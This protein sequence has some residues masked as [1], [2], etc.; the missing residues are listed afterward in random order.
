M[1]PR[2]CAGDA[3]GAALVMAVKEDDR[4]SPQ[5]KECLLLLAHGLSNG[6]LTRAEA[7]RRMERYLAA[8]ETETALADLLAWLAAKGIDASLLSARFGWSG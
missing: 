7:L 1:R 6:L 8:G 2:A 3:Y 5:E 4:L